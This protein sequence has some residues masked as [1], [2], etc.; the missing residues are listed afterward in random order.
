MGAVRTT[1]EEMRARSRLRALA[2]GIRVWV[3]EAGY[4]YAVPST[5]QDATAYEVVVMDGD[6][7]CN[8][9]GATHRGVCK[10]QG[11]VSLMMEAEA[12]LAE[13]Q[14]ITVGAES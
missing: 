8:C 1:L 11:A 2:Q 12:A 4:R 3:L 6:I 5:T 10:H 14:E 13:A 9:P 7:A